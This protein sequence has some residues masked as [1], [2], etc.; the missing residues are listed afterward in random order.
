MRRIY[1]LSATFCFDVV[2][3]LFIV[4]PIVCGV[5][6]FSPCFRMQCLVFFLVLQSSW[7]GERTGS[8]ALIVFLMS[9][10]SVT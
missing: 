5:S 10:D 3:S 6:V 7:R 4:A 8:C 1:A 9:C 2:D